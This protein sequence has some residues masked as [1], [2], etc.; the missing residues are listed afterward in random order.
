MKQL[1]RR[2]QFWGPE[3]LQWTNWYN[4]E[5]TRKRDQWEMKNKL[6]AEFREV[7]L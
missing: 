4:V 5:P 2:Y 1:Q 6:K 7:E 3:G